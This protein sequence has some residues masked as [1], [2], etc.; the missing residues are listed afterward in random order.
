MIQSKERDIIQMAQILTNTEHYAS[1]FEDLNITASPRDNKWLKNIR[2]T[3]M[4]NFSQLGLPT[5][6]KGNENWKYTSIREIARHNY[7]YSPIADDTTNSVTNIS[8]VA[9]WNNEWINLVFIDGH[10]SNYHSNNQE[11]IPGVSV[12]NI[13]RELQDRHP[14]I[15]EHLGSLAPSSSDGFTAL[16]TAFLQDGAIIHVAKGAVIKRPIHLLFISTDSRN[17]GASYPRTL[18]IADEFSKSTIIESYVS[19]G[20]TIHFTNSVTEIELKHN[21]HVEHYRLL[22]EGPNGRHVGIARVNE[23]DESSFQSTSLQKS[24]GLGRYDLY[25]NLGGQ[26]SKCELNGLY[27]TTDREHIDNFINIDHT[28]PHATS[29]LYYKGILDGYSRAVFGGTVW[30]R[31]GAMKTDSQ[32]DDKNLVLSENA[33]VD[34]KP[35]LFIYAD[36]VK[37]GHGANAGN[38]GEDA[39]F[40][41]RSRGID[42]ETA[43]QLLIFGFAREI[44]DKVRIEDLRISLEN[45][46][47]N[48]L[49]KYQ[50][51]F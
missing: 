7:Q 17:Y 13:A 11:T 20:D 32:Q 28:K 15:E 49:P 40:F 31:E 29:K 38:I 27:I 12:S 14:L 9:P 51:Q 16:N 46:F 25:V 10:Y 22:N 33:E 21:A 44:L 37:C 45:L 5:H 48:S 39:V 50:F 43:S 3:G 30:V 36:D 34:S 1:Q 4:E 23:S 35:A 24:T 26:Q 19:Y 47:L 18:L 2:Q 6:R 8:S 41:M 42:L